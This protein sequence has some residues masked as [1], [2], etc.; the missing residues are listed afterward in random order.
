MKERSKKNVRCQPLKFTT[1]N[2]K[3]KEM[4]LTAPFCLLGSRA[5]RKENAPLAYSRF[6]Q[7]LSKRLDEQLPPVIKQNMVSEVICRGSRPKPSL[8][9]RKK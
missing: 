1:V 2:Q 5:G 6:R 9:Y 4:G 3:E 7:V 8:W